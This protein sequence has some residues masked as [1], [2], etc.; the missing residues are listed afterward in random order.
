MSSVPWVEGAPTVETRHDSLPLPTRRSDCSPV[1]L[2]LSACARV[3]QPL[4]AM[5]S[6][7]PMPRAVPSS[8][9]AFN[10]L[11]IQKYA[12]Q[13]L[14]NR[15]FAASLSTPRATATHERH[16]AVGRS[17]PG[18]QVPACAAHI[19]TATIR[20][21]G[22]MQACNLHQALCDR[23]LRPRHMCGGFT[24]PWLL[25]VLNVIKAWG[26]YT[27]PPKHHLAKL[28]GFKRASLTVALPNAES[29]IPTTPATVSRVSP[30][31]ALYS[32]RRRGRATTHSRE[33]AAVNP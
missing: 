8:E 33:H 7:L 29:M 27:K 6:P 21:A 20:A 30:S 10:K 3:W 5:A 14:I 9:Q 25:S 12:T 4:S 22:K 2:L 18:H 15:V 32:A 26:V 17:Y 19:H 16:A 23:F 11:A 13:N 28:M 31:A 1:Y 24:V